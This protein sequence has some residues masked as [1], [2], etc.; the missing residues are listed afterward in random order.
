MVLVFYLGFGCLHCVQQLSTFGPEAEAFARRGI[1]VVAIGTEDRE[2]LAEACAAYRAEGLEIP[3]TMLADPDLDAFRAY[4]AFDRHGHGALHGTFLIDGEGMIRWWDVDDEPFMD[5]A[6]FLEE[7]DRLLAGPGRR[8]GAGG[9]AGSDG[10][11]SGP[12]RRAD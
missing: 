3:F 11:G 9:P 6:F 12:G 1:E 8:S 2:A 10:L 7:A 5:V 4:R